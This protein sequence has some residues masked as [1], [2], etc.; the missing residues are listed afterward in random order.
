MSLELYF[1]PLA[2][3]CWKVLIA[4]YEN[5]TPFVPR[6]IDL[7][8]VSVREDLAKLWP[9]VKVP[10]LRALEESKTIAESSIIIEYLAMCHPGRVELLPSDPE[11]ALETRFR[12]R[13]FDVYVHEPMQKIVGDR[14]LAEEKR[15]PYGVSQARQLIE[16]A[17]GVIERDMADRTWAAGDAFSMADCSAAPA[18]HYANRVVPLGET[19]V[20]TRA[21]LSRLEQRPS[22]RRVLN[23]ARPYFHLFPG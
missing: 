7:G 10:V 14:L 2:S 8:D 17:Y 12:D 19:F 4:L 5:E 22:F 13:F 23:E 16:T 21:Y 15:D 18:L 11:R 3:Y 9:F 1:H 6:F 20:N